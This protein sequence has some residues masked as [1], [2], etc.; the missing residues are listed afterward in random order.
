M[1]NQGNPPAAALE[2]ASPPISPASP[3]ASPPSPDTLAGGNV[4][5]APAAPAEFPE[6]W[7]QKLSGGD[8]KELKR[9]ERFGSPKE[10]AKAYRE[11]EKKMSSGVVKHDLPKDAT[12]EQVTQWRKDN[13]IPE[14]PEGY[15]T[16]L[17]NGIVIGENDKPLVNEFL[18]EMHSANASPTAVNAALTAYYKLIEKQ[19]ADAEAADVDFK[20]QSIEE[21]QMEM[22]AD[23]RKNINMVSNLL[24]TAPDGLKDRLEAS[25]TPDGRKLGDDP[26]MIK[27]LTQL[28][29]EVNPAA[30]LVP[31]AGSN[32][33]QSIKEEKAAIE[34]KMGTGAYTPADRARHM[35]IVAAEAKM[36]SR[37]A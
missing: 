6:D 21:L 2:P 15:D 13:G 25:R 12:P 20:G 31:G 22:G 5:V 18:K 37:V 10:L 3:P 11:L 36:A 7:R 4:P 23:F 24:S 33:A 16:N 30:A 14:A 9:L 17:G 26:A 1:T 29:R 34:A 27:W 32:A 8:E 19:A 35:E 28:A